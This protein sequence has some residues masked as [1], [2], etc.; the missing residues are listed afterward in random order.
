MVHVGLSGDL[1]NVSP[2]G[3]ED[4]M[5]RCWEVQSPDIGAGS[6]RGRLRQCVDF[7][8]KELCAPPWVLHTITKGYV[9]LL[10]SEPTP[11]SRP[12][13]HFAL[14]ELD[15]VYK[16]VSKLLVDG[17]VERTE[18]PPIVCS[19]LSVVASGSRKKRLIVNL[20]HVNQYLWKQKFKYEDLRVAMILFNPDILS[21]GVLPL[22][23]DSQ[24]PDLRCLAAELPAVVLD[25]RADNT[26]N[27]YLGAFQ[28]WKTWAAAH[29]GVPSFPY[30]KVIWPCTWYI[31]VSP[32]NLRQLLK[33]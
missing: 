3:V 22:L 7:W 28:R 11:Y 23:R 30:R 19:P 18:G 6:V 8:R 1:W 32:P 2:G 25:S 13:Q 20:R 10:I 15:F 9:L 29:Q 27:K 24:D 12:N 5:Q 26:T 21:V 14:A 4:C 33:R 17:C 31:S 16:A